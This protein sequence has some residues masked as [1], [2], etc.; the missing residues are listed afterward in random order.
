MDLGAGIRA[1]YEGRYTQ[2][3]LGALVG[4]RQNTVSRW[5]LNKDEPSLATIVAIEDACDRPRGF[6]LHA[7]GYCG[8]GPSVIEAINMDPDLNDTGRA[9]LRAV[10]AS[11]IQVES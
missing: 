9:A 4:V 8:T 1:A 5:V 11:V 7:A 10:Y 3:Q 2:D 6:I